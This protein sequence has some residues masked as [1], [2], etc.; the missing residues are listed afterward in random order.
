MKTAKQQFQQDVETSR[1]KRQVVYENNETLVDTATGE[2]LQLRQ[3]QK[4]KTTTEPDFIKVYY[5]T[6]LAV[7]GIEEM[8][9]EFVLALSSVITY[10]NNPNS[11]IY[12]YNNAANRR[13]ISECCMN[14]KG[15]PISDNMVARHIITATKMGLLFKTPNRGIYEVNPCM[16]ARGRWENIRGLQARFDFTEGKWSRTMIEEQKATKEEVS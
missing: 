6:M 13:I 2:I 10:S 8:P 16:I 14:K 4:I 3:T 9:L 5:K 11:P 7:Q 12:F 15:K 1:A